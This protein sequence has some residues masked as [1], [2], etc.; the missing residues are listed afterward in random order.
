MVTVLN[1]PTDK[2]ERE[3]HSKAKGDTRVFKSRQMNRARNFASSLLALHIFP[4]SE[5]N[6]SLKVGN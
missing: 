6:D 5:T 4:A 2:R 3:T 1:I